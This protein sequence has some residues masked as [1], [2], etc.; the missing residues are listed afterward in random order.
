MKFNV[1]LYWGL[2]GMEIDE[3]A[4]YESHTIEADSI[5]SGK[6]MKVAKKMLEERGVHMGPY[7]RV[8]ETIPGSRLD[9][10]FGSYSNFIAIMD[11]GAKI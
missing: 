5:T 3:R 8:I 9:I 11:A 1:I 2:I 7:Y 4:L 10:D 6:L